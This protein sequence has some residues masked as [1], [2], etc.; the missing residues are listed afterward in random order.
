MQ[1]GYVNKKSIIHKLNPSLKFI[2]FVIVIVMIF[3]PLG[4]F[5][6]II[7][8]TFLMLIYLISKLGLKTFLNI[9]K[10]IIFLFLLLLLIN[11][12]LYK[13]PV[14]IYLPSDT[15]KINIGN[16]NNIYGFDIC[17]D[18]SY[19][20]TLWGGDVYGFL[21]A[22]TPGV[23]IDKLTNVDYLN[24][25]LNNGLTINGVHYMAMQLS[26][27]KDITI[28][29]TIVLYK[30][31]WYTFS[32]TAIISALYISIK[33]FLMI[34][35]AT[36]LTATTSSIELTYALEDILHPLKIFKFPVAETSI[37]IA[38]ALRFIPTLLIESK[39][40]LN[41]QASRGIDI[42]N[43]NLI[44]KFKALSSLII[45]LFNISF[46]KSLDLSNALEARSYNPRY[47][48]T[49]YRKFKLSWYDWLF[50]SFIFILLGFLI[51]MIINNTFFVPFGM[52]ELSILLG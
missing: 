34:L 27:V 21:T 12:C 46:Q 8:T 7:I 51:G 11:W 19:V 40:I 23:E 2:I 13:Q 5:A 52:F 43:G 38:I 31:Y 49:R 42:K 41:A 33:V 24:K 1:L 32:P 28:P 48:R 29:N 14:A 37:M 22:T 3:L 18:N 6:Q 17:V 20:S 44:D 25:I 30:T 26:N 45:P 36:I 16:I 10:S 35:I 39:I 47:S 50:T 4:F 15:F 9:L